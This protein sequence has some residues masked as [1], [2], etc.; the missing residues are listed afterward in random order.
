M[1]TLLAPFQHSL[2]KHISFDSD[3]NDGH[4]ALTRHRSANTRVVV[5]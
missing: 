4:G 1:L 2:L 3:P 5:A